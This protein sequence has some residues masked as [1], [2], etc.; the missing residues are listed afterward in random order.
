VGSGTAALGPPAVL[1]HL[2]KLSKELEVLGKRSRQRWP[3]HHAK[4]WSVR[5]RRP[6]ATLSW[7]PHSTLSSTTLHNC[8]STDKS[9]W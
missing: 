3:A 6:R 7:G 1:A 4:S 9:S 5:A 8:L 2:T